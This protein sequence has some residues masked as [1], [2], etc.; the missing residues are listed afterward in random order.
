MRGGG[1][2]QK[3]EAAEEEP[4]EED[5]PPRYAA[6]RGCIIK[7]QKKKKKTRAGELLGP[8]AQTLIRQTILIIPV[9]LFFSCDSLK[10]NLSKFCRSKNMIRPATTAGAPVRL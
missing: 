2:F 5:A 7:Y 3:A 4:G 9:M 8:C 6:Y 10:L 1:R